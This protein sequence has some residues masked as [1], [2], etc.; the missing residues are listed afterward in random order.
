MT[1]WRDRALCAQVGG[2][3]WFPEA[4]KK[5]PEAKAICQA[6]PVRAQC[7]QYALDAGETA[8]I[9]AGYSG[10]QLRRMRR[11]AA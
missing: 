2:D 7:L 6:C 3:W 8:G 1:G 9:W 5:A 11:D 4:N 10:R